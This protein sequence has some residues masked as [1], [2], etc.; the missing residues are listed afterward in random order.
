[1]K[2]LICLLA[3]ADYYLELSLAVRTG[4]VLTIGAAA[5][6]VAAVLVVHSLRRWRRQTTAATMEYVFPQ[7]GQ[8]I[9]TTVECAELSSTQIANAGMARSLVVALDD[10][11]QS[12]E[13]V[14][15]LSEYHEV[16]VCA[17]HAP[18]LLITQ[19]V[20]GTEPWGKRE[21]SAEMAHAVGAEVDEGAALH[22]LEGAEARTGAVAIAFLARFFEDAE[23]LR[24]EPLAAP[25]GNARPGGFGYRQNQAGDPL[26]FGRTDRN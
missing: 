24:G 13:K 8:R 1:M 10:D 17:V 2:I 12:I 7:L 5:I 3:A 20:W 23:V 14:A 22:G 25:F 26:A 19:R 9:R 21:R 15:H 4:A 16:P 11:S 18:C 6:V